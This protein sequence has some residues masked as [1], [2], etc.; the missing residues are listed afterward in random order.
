MWSIAFN[1]GQRESLAPRMDGDGEVIE[2]AHA[3]DDGARDLQY[4][5]F[6]CLE[7]GVS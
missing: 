7:L 1:T 6:H 3:Q 5:E 2:K 4:V